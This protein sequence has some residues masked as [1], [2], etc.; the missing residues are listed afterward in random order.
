MANALVP[1][2][3]HGATLSVTNINGVPCVALKPIC[4]ALSVDWQ[5]QHARIMRHPVLSSTVSVTKMVAEDGKQRE[6]LFLPLDKL[7]G[8]L[9]GISAA[10]VRDVARRE[11][12]IRYQAEC[13]DVLAR[14][15]GAVKPPVS[16]PP[17]LAP[18]PAPAMPLSLDALV[19]FITS[20][21]IDRNALLHIADAS[22]MALYLNVSRAKDTGWGEAV[23]AQIDD[24]LPQA[25]LRAI[26]NKAVLELWLRNLAAA[27]SERQVPQRSQFTAA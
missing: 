11:L 1:V 21:L 13:F 10:R 26:V 25:D 7:N 18:Q 4:E 5:A 3:F 15:F 8:W 20:G 2:Q 17:E 19:A 6:M 27:K 14:H 9:F 23:A 24:T 12:L 22:S 16:A